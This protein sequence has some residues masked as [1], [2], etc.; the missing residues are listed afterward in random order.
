MEFIHSREYLGKGD[1]VELEIDVPCNFMLTDDQNFSLYKDGEVFGYYGGHYASFPVRISAPYP[2]EW[3]IT[4]DTPDG[5]T[6]FR[7]NLRVVR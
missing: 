6:G 1:A 4:V 2:G 3:N 7:Y 5:K